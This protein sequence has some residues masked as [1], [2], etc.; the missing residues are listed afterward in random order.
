MRARGYFGIAT[1]CASCALFPELGSLSGGENDATSDAPIDVAGDVSIDAEAG[2]PANFCLD[3]SHT[4]CDTFDRPPPVAQGWTQSLL[5]QGTLDLL[6]AGISLPNALE[7]VLEPDAG[8]AFLSE[9]LPTATSSVHLGFWLS[10]DGTTKDAGPEVDLAHIEWNVPPGDAGCTTYGFYIVRDS[11]GPVVLQETYA[12]C[13]SNKNT[14]LPK[15]NIGWHHVDLD[16]DYAN[17]G[18]VTVLFDGTS[19]GPPIKPVAPPSQSTLTL[20]IGGVS[21]RS[22][23]AEWKVLFD[24]VVADV[25]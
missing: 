14:P 1:V 4:F 13:A 17:G 25:K 3:A 23:P 21:S 12:G 6:D 8:K 10:M 24:D 9:L 18:S 5:L 2:A 22:L 20:R 15:F 11:T 16:V 19:I 7:A